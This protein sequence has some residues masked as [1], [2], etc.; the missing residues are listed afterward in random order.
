MKQFVI[1]VAGGS[2]ERMKS[3]IP[4]QF[5][6]VKGIPVLMRSI[7]AFYRFNPDI[8]ITVALP[9]EQITYWQ[10][11]CQKYAFN[12]KHQMVAGG[13]TRFHSV[14]NALKNIDPEGIVAIHDGVRPLVSQQTIQRVFETATLKGNAIPY[15][16]IADSVRQVSNDKNNPVDRSKLKLIQTPQA[17]DGKIIQKA[18]EQP[19]E[20][21]FTDDAGVVEK[22]GQKINLVEGN[23]ENIKITTRVDLMLA[24][25]MSGYLSE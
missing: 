20:P 14:K 18:Y 12:I 24:N 23:R 1:I 22:T 13:E 17:F 8:K 19:Y 2:G 7:R 3:D 6:E 21:S 5:L 9:E 11:L 4:K 15:I 25:T 16:D 10:Q